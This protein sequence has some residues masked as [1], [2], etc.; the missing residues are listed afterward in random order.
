MRCSLKK[1]EQDPDCDGGSEH[2]EAIAMGIAELLLHYLKRRNDRFS[3]AGKCK[4]TL[5]AAPL[6]ED[7]GFEPMRELCSEM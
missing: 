3:G 2:A 7:R 5:V 1:E 4:A 6:L